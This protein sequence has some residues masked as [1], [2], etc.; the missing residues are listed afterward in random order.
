MAAAKTLASVWP[1]LSG[2]GFLEPVPSLWEPHGPSMGGMSGGLSLGSNSR[3]LGELEPAVS[4]EL[5]V[6]LETST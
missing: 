4:Y 5:W 1:Q 2:K 3:S 6:K